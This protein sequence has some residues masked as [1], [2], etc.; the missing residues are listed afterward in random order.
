[1]L[2]DLEVGCRCGDSADARTGSS[3]DEVLL[4]PIEGMPE[5]RSRVIVAASAIQVEQASVPFADICVIRLLC[6]LVVTELE[7]IDQILLLGGR[8]EFL[9]LEQVNSFGEL[10][11]IVAK[12]SGGIEETIHIDRAMVDFDRLENV[13]SY[14]SVQASEDLQAN[15]ELRRGCAI[16]RVDQDELWACLA[17]NRDVVAVTETNDM[18]LE[19]FVLVLASLC[20]LNLARH[21]SVL[22]ERIDDLL[23]ADESVSFAA[24]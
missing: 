19:S 13:T 7:G 9:L 8:S 3:F 14:Q 22:C 5:V 23:G 15:G 18:F 24:G 6:R 1:M 21:I 4:N 17:S 12:G 16:M 10:R 11:D 2:V 20:H